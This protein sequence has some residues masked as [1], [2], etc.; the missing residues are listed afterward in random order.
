M[1]QRRA[2]SRT[3]RARTLRP[4]AAGDGRGAAGSGRSR[5]RDLSIAATR[6]AGRSGG[7]SRQRSLPRTTTP[8][9]RRV[10]RG[11]DCR[12]TSSQRGTSS[13]TWDGPSTASPQCG[14][15]GASREVRATPPHS[16][17]VFMQQ[18][19]SHRRVERG[20][21]CRPANSQ[22]GTSSYTWDEPS[23]SSLQCRACGDEK[24]GPNR[25]IRRRSFM[26]QRPRR[27][28]GWA[29]PSWTVPSQASAP[30]QH[31]GLQAD[32]QATSGPATLSGI[33]PR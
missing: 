9:H 7:A 15:C 13:Y 5:W 10:E 31:S 4:G 23:T 25:P 2:S 29:L 19:P 8:S 27:R 16:Q 21:G 12:P 3:G 32:W 26:Q 17:R 1:Q 22:R 33:V 30:V 24:G 18:R 28:P 14:S 20:P 6:P 11:P